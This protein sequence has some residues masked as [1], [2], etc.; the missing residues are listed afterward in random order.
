MA[1]K[2]PRIQV[3]LTNETA[4]TVRRLAS[5]SGKSASGIVGEILEDAA[6]TLARLCSTIETLRETAESQRSQLKLTLESQQARAEEL[7]GSM[8][9]VVAQ[10]EKVVH[11]STQDAGGNEGGPRRA[12]G[13]S[14]PAAAGR[15][16]RPSNTGVT[17]DTHGGKR[18]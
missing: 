8:M 5:L 14:I 18:R 7:L 17:H 15:N 6:P 9:D 13:A 10:T 16:P 1:T 12:G 4:D 3:T 2:K 11:Q